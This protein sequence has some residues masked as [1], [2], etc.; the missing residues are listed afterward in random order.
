MPLSTTERSIRVPSPT[1]HAFAE[2]D[3]AADVRPSPIRQ[4]RSTIAGG[5]IR[6]EDSTWSAIAM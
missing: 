2:H 1:M 3:E 6:P 5:T 4:P